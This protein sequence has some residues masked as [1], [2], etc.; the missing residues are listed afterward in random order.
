MIREREKR[1]IGT[2]FI[3]IPVTHFLECWVWSD[4]KMLKYKFLESNSIFATSYMVEKS[5][6]EMRMSNSLRISRKKKC[7][8][9]YSLLG[10]NWWENLENQANLVP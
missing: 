10:E 6:L 1:E 5:R 8:E 4:S 2:S 9:K 3:K 7:I